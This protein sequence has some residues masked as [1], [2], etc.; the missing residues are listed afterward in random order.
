MTC[1]H[2]NAELQL[3]KTDYCCFE[4]AIKFLLNYHTFKLYIDVYTKKK[5]LKN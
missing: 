3:K 2:K 4:E 5:D 1:N